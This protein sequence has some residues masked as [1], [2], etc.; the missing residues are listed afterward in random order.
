VCGGHS[1]FGVFR[2]KTF[3]P[4][5]ALPNSLPVPAGVLDDIIGW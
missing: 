1:R 2:G 3:T 5:P 4:L